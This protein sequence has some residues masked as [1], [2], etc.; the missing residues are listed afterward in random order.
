M[1]QLAYRIEQI[2]KFHGSTNKTELKNDVLKITK[3]NQDLW[4]F[5]S[6]SANH[7]ANW[8]QFIHKFV[9]SAIETAI[10]NELALLKLLDYMFL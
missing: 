7:I 4:P 2:H 3:I 5:T 1:I 9:K 8:Q 6:S 10:E